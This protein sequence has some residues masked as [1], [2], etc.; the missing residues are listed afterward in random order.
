MSWAQPTADSPVQALQ[1]SSPLTIK[2]NFSLNRLALRITDAWYLIKT[3][4]DS[5]LV[6]FF[7]T[8]IILHHCQPGAAFEFD[9]IHRHTYF[10]PGISFAEKI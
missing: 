4:V 1:K 5:F 2:L 3:W 9:S 8:W 6:G 7:K 10:G